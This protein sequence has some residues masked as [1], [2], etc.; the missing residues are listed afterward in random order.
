MSSGNTTDVPAA[1]ETVRL[2]TLRPPPG[3]KPSHLK[4]TVDAPTKLQPNLAFRR[5]RVGGPEGLLSLAN[6]TRQ[7]GPAFRRS[8]AVL[9]IHSASRPLPGLSPKMPPPTSE[10]SW[11]TTRPVSPTSEAGS[12]AG[13]DPLPSPAPCQR[14]GPQRAAALPYP[15]KLPDNDARLPR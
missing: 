6:Q 10:R 5:G 13:P 11:R 1:G 12:A 7:S 14:S 3:S 8:P 15:G 2:R 9:L 4:S